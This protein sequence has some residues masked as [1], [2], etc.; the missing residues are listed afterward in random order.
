MK[1][2]ILG[3]GTTVPHPKR[4]SAGYWLET[5][6][7]R[8]LL[9]CSMYAVRQ[10]VELELDWPKLDSIWISHFHLDHV[11]G[12]AP[13]LAGTKHADQM[14]KRR[15]A[16]RIFGPVGFGD[17]LEKFNDANDYKLFQQPFP[18]DIIEVE[19]LERFE[20]VESVNAVAMKTVHTDE[21][22]AIHIR[23]S[24]DSTF[25]YTSDT[26]FDELLGM[27]ASKVDMLVIEASYPKNKTKA[28]HLELAEAM[29]IIRKAAPKR[30][31]LTHLYPEWDKVNFDKE[32]VKYSPPCEV[33]EAT[34]GLQ[35]DIRHS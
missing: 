27:F 8:V 33:I 9:D 25:V 34:D 12:L 20:I 10:L 7:G 2:T 26:G 14:K 4:R 31:V 21:S 32:V 18:V 6:G 17:L 29:Y 5:T 11:G 28:K 30:A 16:L 22:L 35:L 24:D 13:F 1:L 19:P 15:K 23:D 3:S